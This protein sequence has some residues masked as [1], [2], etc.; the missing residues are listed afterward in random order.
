M[1]GGGEE[2]D[3]GGVEAVGS[4]SPDCVGSGP[5]DGVGT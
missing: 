1:A 3:K 2:S 5:G 4:E